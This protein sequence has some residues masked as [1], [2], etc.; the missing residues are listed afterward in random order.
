MSNYTADKVEFYQGD[1]RQWRWRR[2]ASN[3]QII[4]ASTEA[5]K[6]R[7][8]CERNLKAQARPYTVKIVYR[9]GWKPRV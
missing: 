6:S 4:G 8:A 2:T 9:K 3:G 7:K 5:Y 1:D